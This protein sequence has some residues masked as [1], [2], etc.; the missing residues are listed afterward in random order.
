MKTRIANLLSVLV[1]GLGSAAL[2]AGD[3]PK[4]PAK[5]P[6][7]KLPDYSK[8]TSVIKE[9]TG[10]VV[11]VAEN[12]LTIKLNNL[13][14][15]KG[16]DRNPPKSADQPKE[17]TYSFI[18][19][20]LVRTSFPPPKGED[21]GKT[22][23]YTE[24][25]KEKLK[26]PPGAPGYA[27]TINDLAVGT[28]V[29]LQLIRDKTIPGAQAIE[30]DLR[31]KFAIIQ[32]ES[33]FKG[34]QGVWHLDSIESPSKKTE[35]KDI[36]AMILTIKDD[37]WALAFGKDTVKDEQFS[38]SFGP[39]TDNVN[40]A[41]ILLDSKANPKKMALLNQFSNRL[42]WSGLYKL[43]GDTLTICRP[44]VL[45]GAPP[46]ELKSTDNSILWLWRRSKDN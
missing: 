43:E 38:M 21:K 42:I 9:V 34:L 45:S 15:K 25:E 14:P 33:P 19:E 39:A 17:M 16:N 20:S 40:R 12:K 6:P 46:G 27:A 32:P 22:V 18:E 2:A 11:K 36:K 30:D 35:Y 23:A 37:Q 26:L 41:T 1:L 5:E 8:Y 7:T 3:D 29:K 10:D 31:I 4:P 24:K 13:P 44:R 28:T